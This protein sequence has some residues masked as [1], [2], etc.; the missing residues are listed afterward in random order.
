MGHPKKNLIYC[1]K[2]SRERHKYPNYMLDLTAK[3]R[4]FTRDGAP[5]QTSLGKLTVLPQTLQLD[6]RILIGEKDRERGGGKE[7][8]P[9]S[10]TSMDTKLYFS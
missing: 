3:M 5:P 7:E 10:V 4:N 8:P 2:F 1:L 9:C 6:I